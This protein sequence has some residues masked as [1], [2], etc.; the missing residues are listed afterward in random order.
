MLNVTTAMAMSD[1]RNRTEH[2][3]ISNGVFSKIVSP[4]GSK[5]PISPG[6]YK[7]LAVSQDAFI[8]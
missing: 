3:S 2:A 6:G 4:A 8:N 1:V 7:Q 5:L